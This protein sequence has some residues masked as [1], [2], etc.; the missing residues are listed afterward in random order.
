MGVVYGWFLYSPKIENTARH[1]HN[2][3]DK[4]VVQHPLMGCS[5][6]SD[7]EQTLEKQDLGQILS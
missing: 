3:S 7:A 4:G 2:D 6:K 5:E 1:Q